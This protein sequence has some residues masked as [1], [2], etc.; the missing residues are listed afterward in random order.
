MLSKPAPRR[1]RVPGSRC[2]GSLLTTPT[3]NPRLVLGARGPGRCKYLFGKLSRRGPRGP[4]APRSEALTAILVFV[5]AVSG[6]L[7]PVAPAF[8]GWRLHRVRTGAP[9]LVD[10]AR[11]VGV[12]RNAPSVRAC[13]ARAP[14]GWSAGPSTLVS[15]R[16]FS[17]TNRDARAPPPSRIGHNA[18]FPR[19]LAR[20]GARWLCRRV[21]KC[22]GTSEPALCVA[23]RA[24]VIARHW[25]FCFRSPRR[26]M[27]PRPL[28]RR[29]SPTDASPPAG[30]RPQ[31]GP[32]GGPRHR[33]PLPCGE[34]PPRRRPR[35]AAE[36]LHALRPRDDKEGANEDALDSWGG[37]TDRR[38]PHT[39]APS[40][41]AC[42]PRGPSQRPPPT[43]VF[44]STADG[45]FGAAQDPDVRAALVQRGPLELY[46]ERQ[47]GSA[48]SDLAALASR[49]SAA[50]LAVS[51]RRGSPPA[52]PCDFLRHLR[53]TSLRVRASPRV[54]QALGC[55]CL[56]AP[57]V[58][59]DPAFRE[60][61]L[62]P[63]ADAAY[64]A[65][66]VSKTHAARAPLLPRHPPRATRTRRVQVRFPASSLPARRMPCPRCSWAPPRPSLRSWPRCARRWRACLQ[67]TAC[68]SRPGATR[69]PCCPSGCPARARS[70]AGLRTILSR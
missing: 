50:G 57:D 4:P 22:T 6:G 34:L 27:G 28:P 32:P 39:G 63:L 24:R 62:L 8:R 66:L 38:G 5:F 46:V 7:A 40:R 48:R 70:G 26:E 21:G 36:L 69:M 20:D 53:H 31:D 18:C 23:G 3:P 41:R 30:P 64:D 43:C 15:L 59:V 17:R 2:C 12:P 47:C 9:S 68:R 61:F 52:A 49:I 10:A 51:V 33:R 54:A 35:H 19:I 14:P 65:V 11:L 56:G 60:Q 1:V 37:N 42:P 55:G 44:R 29:S 13:A 58:I 45:L 16:P 67:R 25:C